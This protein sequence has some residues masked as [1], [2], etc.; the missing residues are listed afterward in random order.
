MEEFRAFFDF[1]GFILIVVTA[2]TFSKWI[3]K[4]SKEEDSEGAR[5]EEILTRLG[6]I[7]QRLANLET[8]VLETEK[9]KEF[10]RLL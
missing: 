4:Q 10:E 6:R 2:G 7:E 1:L 8:I 3:R 5:Q 9:E